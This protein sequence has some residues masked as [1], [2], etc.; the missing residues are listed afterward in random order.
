M[1]VVRI[2]Q[3]WQPKHFKY[4]F[5]RFLNTP[6]R[7]GNVLCMWYLPYRGQSVYLR[8]HWIQVDKLQGL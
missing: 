5:W 8:N 7:M 3:S 2:S 1:I 4:H 6:L